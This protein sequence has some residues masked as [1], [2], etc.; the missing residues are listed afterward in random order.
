M[1]LILNFVYTGRI[2]CSLQNIE[3]ILCAADYFQISLITDRCGDILK[4]P[5]VFTYNLSQNLFEK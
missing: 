2:L 5:F 4:T 3:K 1:E